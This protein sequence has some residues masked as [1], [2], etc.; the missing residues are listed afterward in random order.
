MLYNVNVNHNGLELHNRSND[1]D[2]LS[3]LHCNIFCLTSDLLR[4]PF[5]VGVAHVEYVRVAVK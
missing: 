3:T 5:E 4:C 2:R 1:V